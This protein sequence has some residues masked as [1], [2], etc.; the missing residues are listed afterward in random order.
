MKLKRYQPFIYLLLALAFSILF[1][2]LH[3][4]SLDKSALVYIGFPFV[5]GVVLS[6]IKSHV[7]RNDPKVESWWRRSWDHFVG[8][9]VVVLASSLMLFEGF[10]C[11]LMLLPVYYFV[12][13]FCFG[14]R[15]MLRR[16][17]DGTRFFPA[18]SLPIV[19]VALSLEGVAPELSID[20]HNQVVISQ[21][22]NLDISTIR[23]NLIKPIELSEDRSA[24]LKLFPMPYQISGETLKQGDVHK[25][26][27]RYHRW[28]VT[29]THE[30]SM[31]LKLSEVEDQRIRTEFLKDTSYISTY[32]RLQSTE[33]NFEPL[34]GGQT[35]V[36]LS[37]EYE[38]RLDPA[39]YFGP[40]QRYAV[41]QMAH[42][43][44]KEVMVRE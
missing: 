9:S 44:I 40:L 29:N 28:F 39:W 37:I 22:V 31:W 16:C 35:R 41:E 8:S 43:L 5:I 23:E 18:H 30:G 33:I 3:H 1:R 27:F 6:A 32:M 4:F 21:D 2:V 12:I 42:H 14:V 15:E 10:I 38:R 11:V 26:D 36:S 34:A 7:E 19:M 20:R 24:L 25:I 17:E 13:L